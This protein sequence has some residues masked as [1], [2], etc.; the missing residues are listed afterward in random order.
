MKNAEN[1][2]TEI[3]YKDVDNLILN[4][5]SEQSLEKNIYS[6]PSSNN[7]SSMPSTGLTL[8][9]KVDSYTPLSNS[10]NPQEYSHSICI[11]NGG[12]I[13]QMYELHEDNLFKDNI[14]E[15]LGPTQSINKN[16]IN[17]VKHEK[18]W[19]FPYNNGIT[20]ETTKCYK[21]RGH[22][23]LDNAS[24]INGAQSVS[25]IYWSYKTELDNFKKSLTK[26]FEN[27]IITKLQAREKLSKFKEELLNEYN[28]I[29]VLAKVIVVDEVNGEHSINLIKA[30]NSQNSVK[31]SDFWSNDEA[32]IKLKETLQTKFGLYYEIKRGEFDRLK[33]TELFKQTYKEPF[34]FMEDFC[35]NYVA[36]NYS[37]G[38]G[39][40]GSEKLFPKDAANNLVLNDLQKNEYETTVKMLFSHFLIQS[41]EREISLFFDSAKNLTQLLTNN[42]NLNTLQINKLKQKLN[43]QL[44][45]I[46]YL[47]Y[48]ND[49][50][51]GSINGNQLN[52]YFHNTFVLGNKSKYIYS[53][54]INRLLINI[55]NKRGISY[56]NYLLARLNNPT[57]IDIENTTKFL[58]SE[59]YNIL[60]II[61]NIFKSA[62]KN[63]TDILM[64]LDQNLKNDIETAISSYLNS[65]N[66][67]SA[68]NS[69]P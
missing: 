69:L 32:Q 40:H 30:V 38:S 61:D 45:N 37:P 25:C 58:T 2:K 63:K 60:P 65:A 39:S 14:R 16:I 9:L 49:L 43:N 35:R 31:K 12:V 24:I 28:I 48:K 21:G 59:I 5:N 1:T 62:N 51:Q 56:E 6:M 18:T 7:N 3:N 66:G 15:F 52:N 64:N 57:F 33:N 26:D 47:K 11:I 53:Y 8:D 27:K 67:I 55:L 20:F 19:F 36:I 41:I 50:Q 23:V 13:C 29:K 10:N 4:F 46:N 44:N 17:T 68:I 22:I 54:I 42:A 34:L